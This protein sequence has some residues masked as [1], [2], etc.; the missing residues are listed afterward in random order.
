MLFD[1]LFDAFPYLIMLISMRI[2]FI[3]LGVSNELGLEETKVC[4]MHDGDKIG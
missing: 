3:F 2:P 4:G 1:Q